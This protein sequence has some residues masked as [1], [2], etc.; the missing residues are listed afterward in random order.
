MKFD[1]WMVL[2]IFIVGLIVCFTSAML[3]GGEAITGISIIYLAAVI[4]GKNSN[5]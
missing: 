5:K 3:L 4:A 1:Y 2:E